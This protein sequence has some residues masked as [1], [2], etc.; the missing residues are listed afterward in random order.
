MIF[1]S[2]ISGVCGNPGQAQYAAGN[3]FQDELA[4][5]RRALGLKAVSVNLGVMLDVGVIAETGAH[6]FKILEQVLGIREPAF[7]ALM[8]SLING[9]QKKGPRQGP[10]L[11]LPPNFPRLAKT[12]L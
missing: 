10:A 5:H 12:R 9:R 4:H 7:H 8:R 6:N 1:C 3:A 11:R 2:S